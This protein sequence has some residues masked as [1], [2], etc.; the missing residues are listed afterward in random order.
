M[1]PLLRSRPLRVFL[2]VAPTVVIMVAV[3]S[4]DS[5]PA[6]AAAINAALG[7]V[8]SSSLFIVVSLIAQRAADEHLE[9]AMSAEAGN[10]RQRSPQILSVRHHGT[11]LYADWYFRVRLQEEIERAERYDVPMAVLL[12]KM[13]D[14]PDSAPPASW[15]DERIRKVLRRTDLA[16]LLR[17]GSLGVLVPQVKRPAALKGRI[18]AAL[19][20]ARPAIGLASFPHDG[21]DGSALLQAADCAADAACH[22]AA[23]SR[24]L[25]RAAAA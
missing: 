22:G 2:V 11:L 6:V 5:N 18:E 9:T 15:I 25:P 3:F 7:A 16:A 24:Q 10:W 19:S 20:A 4:A 23:A 13:P 17:D 14:V 1:R 12:V 8:T 21:A